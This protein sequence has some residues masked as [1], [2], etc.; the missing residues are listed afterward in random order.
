MS[1]PDRVAPRRPGTVVAAA[2]VLLLMAV[3]AVAYAVT[4]LAVAGGTVDRFR[5]AAADTGA[6]GGDIDRVAGL[7]R[8]STVLAAVLGVLAALLLLGL[9]L[10]LLAGR[11]G[12]RVATWVVAGLG[13]L[14]GCCGLAVL[15]GQRAAPLRLGADD[16]VTADLLGLV[17]DAYPAWWIP[18][19]AALSVAQILGYLVVAALLTLPSANAFLHRPVAPRSGPATGYGATVSG[20]PVSG[21][22]PWGPPAGVTSPSTPPGPVP[23]SSA[24]PVAPPFSSAPPGPVPPSSAPVGPTPPPSAPPVTPPSGPTPPPEDRP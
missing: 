4:N 24:P 19:N 18:L 11:P 3:G 23:P 6:G 15:V 1:N 14:C 20:A 9:A 22:T 12:A 13:L 8:G 17:G 16:R 21:P 10:G 5:A 2:A 7:L